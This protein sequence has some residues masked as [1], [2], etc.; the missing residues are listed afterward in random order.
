M[1]CFQRQPPLFLKVS[2]IPQEKTCIGVFFFPWN[3]E[4]KQRHLFSINKGASPF[5][6]Y[7]SCK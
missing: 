7:E 4:I 5:S 6:E 2:Q 1:L 3:D